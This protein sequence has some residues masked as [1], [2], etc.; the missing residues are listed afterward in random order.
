MAIAVL[1]KK[2][3]RKENSRETIR[4]GHIYDI[5]KRLTC[6]DN[7]N[8]KHK[9]Q[10]LIPD[11]MHR[12]HIEDAVEV[13]DRSRWNGK[14]VF[15]SEAFNRLHRNSDSAFFPLKD[16]VV[17]R[18]TKIEKDILYIGRIL[19]RFENSNHQEVYYALIGFE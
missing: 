18:V 4:R 7:L 17:I 10:L 19:F 5:L 2:N 13:I 14:I 11:W 12:F 15:S 3:L 8:G 16:R 6:N 9:S 1:E